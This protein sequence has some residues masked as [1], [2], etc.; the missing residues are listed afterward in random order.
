MK[1]RKDIQELLCLPDGQREVL[2]GNIAFAIGA[3]RAGFHA[4]DGYPGTPSTEVID[5][6]LAHLPDGVM[7]V[8]WSVNEA[9]AL[10]VAFGH[11]M[12]GRDVIC[13]MKIPGLR[14][15]GDVFSSVAWYTAPRGAL[16]LFIASDYT[17]SSTQ[18]LVDARY[19]ILSCG[20]PVIETGTHQEMLLAAP[21]AADIARRFD[22][23][24]V[25]LAAGNLCHSEG[26][27]RLNPRQE[28]PPREMTGN[29]ESYFQS[30]FNIPQVARQSYDRVMTVRLPRLAE[31]SEQ[32]GHHR[33]IPGDRRLG[34]VAAGVNRLYLREV[35]Q[36]LGLQPSIL[37][38]GFYPLPHRL[39]K[40]FA[41]GIDGELLV[42]E[43]G[44]DL[45][46]A[47]FERM[48]IRVR[49][50]DR[51]DVR[52]EWPP[53]FIA[54]RL[55]AAVPHRTFSISPVPR[56]PGLCP[57]CPYRVFA[58]A[59][60]KLKKQKK[61]EA[62]FGDIGCN[63]LLYF[64][65]AMDTVVCMGAS[66]AVRQGVVLS[67]PELAA[68][69]ISLLGESTEC[70]SGKDAT[71]NAVFRHVPGV[72]VVLNNLCTAMTGAQPDPASPENLDG[73]P[74]RFNLVDSLRGEGA[75]VIHAPAYDLKSVESALQDAL[76]AAG[77]NEFTVIVLEASCLQLLP[78]SQK[79]SRYVIDTEKCI[80][81]G[82]C[83]ICPGIQAEKG[84]VP[85]FT[86]LCAGCAD[87]PA[88]LCAQLC[89]R[90]AIVLPGP[91]EQS[92]PEKV[93]WPPVPSFSLPSPPA[94]LPESVR[95]GIRGVGGQ[96]ILFLGKILGRLGLHLG[97]AGNSNI[98]KGE[99]HG[100]A[101]LGGPV[102][103]T[104][105]MGAVHS[106][107]FL[108]GTADVL[109]ALEQSEVLRPGFAAML[110]PGGTI[111]LSTEKRIPAGLKKD[112]YPELEK[113]RMELADYRVL[114]FDGLAACRTLGDEAGQLANVVTLGLLSTL[115]PFDAFPV[116]FW[117]QALMDGSP[118]EGMRRANFRAFEAGRQ[119]RRE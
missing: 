107:V 54:E 42:F 116:E 58:Q 14:Q 101:Q 31:F 75:R 51:F 46:Q 39:M 83:L 89:P 87:A 78:G 108:P 48:G 8:G 25:V 103:S 65:G 17:P 90:G 55:G 96:G 95:I 72:K 49:G 70:H 9:V 99:T 109:I 40:E 67:C 16:V 3:A 23:P 28:R 93:E 61:L 94:S 110:K 106:P 56:P 63:T 118:Q 57:G 12:A 11:S 79:Q 27:V 59:V 117:W 29:L 21:E 36:T 100:M 1:K 74:S 105:A 68:K 7:T 47:E 43:D 4:A 6:G 38:I 88:S 50:K 91:D 15:A 44:M 37:E 76:R 119:L 102:T 30:F 10:G 60:R 77:E 97:F 24:V 32:S 82:R 71:R 34:V 33:M 111:L 52:T 18:H 112:E 41:A 62:V 69:T 84:E 113:I 22:T 13:T 80:R 86:H 85:V 66:D 104:F 115:P 73:K 26:L 2:Q 98:I 45:I 19:E 20:V 64:L 92:R 5:K 53:A 35:C 81:C 114:E